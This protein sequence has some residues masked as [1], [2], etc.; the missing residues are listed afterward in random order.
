MAQFEMNELSELMLESYTDL[1]DSRLERILEDR[2][3]DVAGL[4]EAAAYSVS[5]GGKRVRPVLAMEFCRACGGDTDAALMFA[6]ALELIH[7][8]S[9][10][11][12]D[13]PCMDNDDLRRG[14]PS[15]HKKF[16]ENTALLAGDLLEALAFEV[17]CDAS[18][19]AETKVKAVSMLSKAT[20]LHG[21]LGGQFLDMENE[22]NEDVDIDRLTKTHHQKTRA[23][24]KTACMLGVLAAGGS[25]EQMAA[26]ESFGTAL[27]LAFQIQD[28]ILDVTGD[29]ASLGKPAGSDEE[30]NKVTYVTLLGLEG[31][32]EMATKSSME[33]LKALEAFEDSSFLKDLTFYLLDRNK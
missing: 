1:V 6:C 14:Q 10:I 17:A 28:D 19:S 32:R 9:L 5:V 22:N 25:K 15:C 30:E 26:A 27:G 13:M 3:K 16:G 2:D 8:S 20:G 7:T 21:M 18:V 29:T 33:A 11:H 12:D 31:A 4:L 23:L 24:I